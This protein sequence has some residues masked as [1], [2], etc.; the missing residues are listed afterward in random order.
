MG[1]LFYARSSSVA[2]LMGSRWGQLAPGAA[3]NGGA[4][5]FT[6]TFLRNSKMSRPIHMVILA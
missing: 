6:K 1:Y 5:Y 2:L 3:G 4:K